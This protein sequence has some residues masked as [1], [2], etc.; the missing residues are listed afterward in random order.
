MKRVR[1][2][3]ERDVRPMFPRLHVNDS[4][5][6]GPRAPPR[7]KIALYEQLSIPSQRFHPR[8]FPSI[9]E[10]QQVR[11][12]AG[13]NAC[14]SRHMCMSTLRN[15]S[16]NSKVR[17]ADGVTRPRWRKSIGNEDD[18]TVPVLVQSRNS[19][20]ENEKS[21]A[22]EKGGL[23]IAPIVT[24]KQTMVKSSRGND[25]HKS[26]SFSKDPV[27]P[28]TNEVGTASSTDTRGQVVENSSM[29][30]ELDAKVLQRCKENTQSEDHGQ[31][32][33]FIGSLED[34]SMAISTQFGTGCQPPVLDCQPADTTVLDSR[35]GAVKGDDTTEASIIDSTS[36]TEISP[37]DVIEVIGQKHFQKAR[38]LI[39]NQQM[40]FARQ[41]F[42]LHRLIKVQKLI[43]ESPLIV[44]KN[45]PVYGNGKCVPKRPSSVTKEKAEKER[46]S[47]HH[48]ECSAEGA[49][50][51]TQAASPRIINQRAVHGTHMGDYPVDPKPSNTSIGFWSYPRVLGH[52]WLIPVL[53]PSEGPI[54]KPFPVPGY[55]GP[56]SRGNRP[57]YS[58]F[59]G[60]FLSPMYGFPI[61]QFAGPGYFPSYGM[62]MSFSVSSS[63]VDQFSAPVSYSQNGPAS[64]E[65]AE[66][67]QH[68]SYCQSILM[69]KQ[70]STMKRKIQPSNDSELQG[71][72]GSILTDQT[73]ALGILPEDPS[74]AT[75]E[76]TTGVIKVVP[77]NPQSAIECAAKI[78]WSIQQER[79][80]HD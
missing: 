37:D 69:E 29:L 13:W 6:A 20:C 7:N 50:A 55:P 34:I 51:K 44:V 18:L 56:V 4:E 67:L 36:A 58:P 76:Q 10:Q 80:Q 74:P 46:P 28:G 40:A 45:G 47:L 11:D 75:T 64:R 26:S 57:Y 41:V 24:A 35:C 79:K 49:V 17:K 48:V 60:K 30:H 1:D 27:A 68:Q 25:L 22:K 12:G 59:M 2:A 39:V 54:Y 62:A 65:D 19:P 78:F 63:I 8:A 32:Y 33:G 71:S 43:A 38:Q 53:S 61:H 70:G 3:N 21:N 77:H 9:P 66:G 73:E 23:A 16:E 5:N 42:E 31:G 52:Q 15:H 14:A 72:T